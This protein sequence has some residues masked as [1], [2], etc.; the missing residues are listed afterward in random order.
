[1][2]NILFGLNLIKEITVIEEEK[3]KNNNTE[4]EDF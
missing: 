4:E 3:E 1:M 2:F